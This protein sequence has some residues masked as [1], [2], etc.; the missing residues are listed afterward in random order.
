LPLIAKC[1]IFDQH[2]NHRQDS[3]DADGKTVA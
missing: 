2:E 3:F 1:Y